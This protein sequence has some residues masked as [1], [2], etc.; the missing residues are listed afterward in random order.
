MIFS[1]FRINQPKPPNS[2]RAMATHHIC[3]GPGATDDWGSWGGHLRSNEVKIR[4]SPVTPDRMKIETR[5]WCQTTWF[6]KPLRKICILTYFVHDLTLTWPWS[7]LTW[8]QILKL[9]F[10]CKKWMVRIDSTN[11]T[12]R[13]H[14]YFCVCHVSN[15]LSMKNHPVKKR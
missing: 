8:G 10:Q 12:I 11:Q 2:F 15:N 6:V 3:D 13:C 14:S 7:K 1:P 4:F 9:T 5:K